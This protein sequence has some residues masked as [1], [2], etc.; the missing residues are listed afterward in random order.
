MKRIVISTVVL[1]MWITS[2]SQTW[3]TYNTDNSDIPSNDIFSVYTENDSTIWLCYW[4]GLIRYDCEMFTEITGSPDSSI[5]LQNPNYIIK[6]KNGY[7]W[8][9]SEYEGLYKFKGDEWTHY[10][11]QDMGFDLGPYESLH[12]RKI[13]LQHGGPGFEAGALWIATYARGVIKYDGDAWKIYDSQNT[14]MPDPG[15]HAVAVED[16]PTGTNYMV[17][18]GTG[19]GLVKF[20]GSSWEIVGVDEEN[21]LWINAITFDK[22]GITFDNG[23][24]YVGSEGGKFGI[25]KNG[26]WD[27][28]NMADAWNPNNSVQD[29]KVDAAHNVWMAT[30]EEG[31]AFYDETQFILYYQS[32]SGIPANNVF[33]I[34]VSHEDDSVFVWLCPN[35][36][37]LTSFSKAFVSGI[38]ENISNSNGLCLSVMPNPVRSHLKLQFKVPYGGGA[39]WPVEISLTDLQG[40]IIAVLFNEPRSPENCTVDY[41]MDN[42]NLSHG[43]YCIIM[44]AG[45][46]TLT[47]K[48][49]VE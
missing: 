4:G 5:V 48:I 3:K 37:G 44:H 20:D 19:S 34:D 26:T 12:L 9:S 18:V 38:N 32:N 39:N 23:V 25:Y 7:Y 30:S 36:T 45:N 15:V 33:S 46:N 40:K 43:V 47:K 27:V 8:V 2:A 41:E 22:G 35:Y 49:V 24:M 31:L 29:I 21:D 28:Y 6:D 13:A 10:T 1:M 11:P 42:F 14:I 17:W 16:A